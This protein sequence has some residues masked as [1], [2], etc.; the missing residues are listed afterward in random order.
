MTAK[1]AAKG[2]Q[3]SKAPRR[4]KI[5]TNHATALPFTGLDAL[6]TFV[7]FQIFVPK[8]LMAGNGALN[9]PFSA[10]WRVIERGCGG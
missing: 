4:E 6:F 1:T 7:G 2:N 3:G 8:Q 5:R 9:K 10:G